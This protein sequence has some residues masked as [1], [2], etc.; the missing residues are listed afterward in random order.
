MIPLFA[1]RR[2]LE[3]HRINFSHLDS[4]V[5]ELGR[6][7]L[8]RLLDELGQDGPVYLVDG[9]LAGLQRHGTSWA[10]RGERIVVR[11]RKRI[12]QKLISQ[13]EAV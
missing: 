5:H 11:C 1:S 3:A 12:S 8:A 10:L 6:R 2:V 7:E 9:E 13:T 4:T